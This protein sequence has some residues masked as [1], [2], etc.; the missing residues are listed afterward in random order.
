MNTT[1][2]TSEKSGLTS[3]T[4][5][6]NVMKASVRPTQDEVR[7][8]LRQAC[9]TICSELP[10]NCTVQ[11][12]MNKLVFKGGNAQENAYCMPPNPI[13]KFHCGVCQSM[14]IVTEI[15]IVVIIS[16]SSDGEYVVHIQWEP[17]L[18]HM[19]SHSTCCGANHR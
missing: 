1:Q 12:H 9:N 16:L 19:E 11:S 4:I 5:N 14:G 7:K 18:A 13:V 17:V 8:Y 10:S 2:N 6:V 15:S 3:E